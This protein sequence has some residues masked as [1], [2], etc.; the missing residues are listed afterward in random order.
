[1]LEKCITFIANCDFC[2]NSFDTDE[3]EFMP[4]VESMKREGWKVFKENG[5]WQHKCTSCVEDMFEDET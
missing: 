2:S 1:M 4:A 3:D 5:E